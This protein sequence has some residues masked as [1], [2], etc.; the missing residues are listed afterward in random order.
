MMIERL[1]ASLAD[2]YRLEREL[3]QGG[4]ATVYLAQDLK[5]DRQ[6]AIKVL[7]PELAAVLGADRFVQEIKTTAAL[8]H[9]HILPLFDSGRAVV[10]P[11]RGAERGTGGEAFLYYV[12]PFIDGET[13]RTKLNRETQLGIEEAVR[14][15]TQVADA[16]DYAHRHGVIH[17]DIKPENILLHDGRPVV[18][19][20]GIALAVSAAAGGRMTETGLS[21]GTPH[22]MSPEQATAEKELTGRSDVYSLASVLYEM[23]TGNPP[24]TGAAAQQIIM[25]IVTEEV[26]PVTK[27]RRNVPPNVAAAVGKALEKLPAD[28]F[29]TAKAF[30]DALTN[31]AFALPGARRAAQQGGYSGWRRYAGAIIGAVALVAVATTIVAVRSRRVVVAIDTSTPA[32]KA[33]VAVLPFVALSAGADDGYFADGLTEEILNSLAALPDLHVTA[34]TSSFYFKGKDVPMDEIATRLGVA[35][36]VEGSVRR[37]GDRV[38]VTAQLIR[39][40]DGFH[41]WSDTYDASIEDVFTVQADIAE[42]VAGALSIYLDDKQ[43]EAIAASGTRNVEAFQAFLKGRALFNQAHEPGASLWDANEEFERAMALDPKYVAPAIAHHDAYA[44]YLMDGPGSALLKRPRGRAPASE[45]E[46]LERLLADLDRA[47]KNAR[48]PTTRIVAELHKEFFSRGWD[49]MPDLL[50]QLREDGAIEEVSGFAVWLPI[51]L[52]L[53]GEFEMARRLSERKVKTD[54]LDPSAW[55]ERAQIFIALGDFDSG[56]DAINRGRAVAGDHPWLRGDELYLAIA[57]RDRERVVALLK[58]PG[59]NPQRTTGWRDAYL[60]AVE[61][62][63]DRA[64]RLAREIEAAS[65]WPVEYL[66]LVYHETGDRT[67][68]RALTQRID[69]LTAGPAIFA[70]AIA[71]TEN[72]L[73]FDLADAPNLAARLD[74]ARIDRKAFRPMPRLSAGAGAMR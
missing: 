56:E 28:R 10:P 13:L 31:P 49:R 5:H 8:Q 48:T 33:S 51:I 71:I 67:R 61:G 26:A 15:T 63:Y 39:A 35:H 22:Y 16:L 69:A 53:N 41:L 58:R 74:E 64:T 34:R 62:D 36:V 57:R 40:N 12:M 32:E 50:K 23:L 46:A 55:S 14:I 42:K 73:Y 47:I 43:R 54:P 1:R 38:R 60:A 68:A 2:R 4:M 6:V 24:H 3:G 27:L 7:K 59:D 25:K 21:L 19:D 65:P 45:D 17:R 37:A 70:R 44:H 72:M 66:L 11:L 52:S 30:A 9:P 20:F 29:E 18:A